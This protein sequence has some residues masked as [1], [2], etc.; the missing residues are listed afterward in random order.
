M[1]KEMSTIWYMNQF[2]DIEV[3]LEQKTIHLF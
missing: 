2:I 1:E 3:I